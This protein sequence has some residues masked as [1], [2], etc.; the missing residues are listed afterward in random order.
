MALFEDNCKD[1]DAM[2]QGGKY[3]REPA[4]ASR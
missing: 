4:H 2:P 3:P 1:A